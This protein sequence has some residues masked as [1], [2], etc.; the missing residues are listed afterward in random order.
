[1]VENFKNITTNCYCII[2]AVVTGTGTNNMFWYYHEG[3]TS[4][5]TYMYGN[6]GC[7]NRP[8]MN[9]Q[10]THDPA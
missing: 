2:T 7:S 9:L 8:Y 6:N 4:T 10:N 1:M 3:T 5:L